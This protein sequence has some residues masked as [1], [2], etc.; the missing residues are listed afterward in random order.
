[1]HWPV[2]DLTEQCRKQEKKWQHQGK[3]MSISFAKWC[4]IEFD[5][6]CHDANIPSCCR[7]FWWLKSLSCKSR[8][9]E[10][11]VI[12][13]WIHRAPSLYNIDSNTASIS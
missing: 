8:M 1:M 3:N 9:S 13:A 5:Q 7:W 6:I 11:G 2:I 10:N 12:R 4:K